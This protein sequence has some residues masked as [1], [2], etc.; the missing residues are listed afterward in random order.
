M[1]WHLQTCKDLPVAR[2]GTRRS[3]RCMPPMKATTILA[4]LLILLGASAA[5]ADSSGK[6]AAPLS[7]TLLDGSV[8]SLAQQRGHVVLI[9]Y[10]ASW[11]GP[12]KPELPAFV[13]YYQAHH[14]EGFD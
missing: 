9:N 4:S 13:R 3:S 10:W 11:C 7:A 2:A 6:L 5:V 1:T 12:C 8:Y 14:A